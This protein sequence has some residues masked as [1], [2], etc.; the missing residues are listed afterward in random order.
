MK[1]M[2]LLCERVDGRFKL[3]DDLGRGRFRSAAWLR[4]GFDY[5]DLVGGWVYFHPN[6]KKG[7]STFGGVVVGV[8]PVRYDDKPRFALVFDERQEAIGKAWRGHAHRNAWTG[9]LV[10]ASLAHEGDA[11]ERRTV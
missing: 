3:V 2:H 7:P 8:E 11:D 5:E 6:G 10:D 1:A 4:W 9:G